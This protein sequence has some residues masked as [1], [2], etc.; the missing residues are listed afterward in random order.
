MNPILRNPCLASLIGLGWAALAASAQTPPP[1][2]FTHVISTAADSVTVD[3]VLRSIRSPNFGVI[4]Q[5]AD[6]SYANHTADVPRTYLG[7]VR[8]RPGALAGA[9]LRA[10]GT[11]WAQVV[12][13]TGAAWTTKGG[14]AQAIA[15]G[16]SSPLW[17]EQLVGEGGLGSTVYAV[18]TGLDIAY[19]HFVA[20]GGTPQ[21]AL[22]SAEFSL[23]AA[24]LPYLRDA[25]I[26]NRLGKI[27]IRAQRPHDPY[28]A[29]GTDK[30]ALLQRVRAL[31]TAGDPMGTTHHLAALIHRDLN[32]GLA[33]GGYSG[34][35][36]TSL[37]YAAVDSDNGEFWRVWRH[38]AGHNWGSGHTEG[39]AR[40][41][42]D[43]IMSG[44]NALSHFSSAEL[45][46]IVGHRN[47]QAALFQN[48]GTYPLPLP[49]R[50]NLDTASFHRNTPV[51]IDVLRNDSDMNG[52]ALTVV[53]SS[54]TTS[55][56]GLVT[57]LA[58]A[59]PGGRDV[60]Q[61]T[62]PPTLGSG[63][64]WFRYRIRDASGREGV[65][66]AVL[67]PRSSVLSLLDHWRL[68]NLAGTVA[69][70]RVRS[71]H[72]GTL[73]NGVLPGQP[74]L[75]PAT[76]KGV[77]FD[78]VDDRIEMP[79]S[80][81]TTD[82][83]SITAWIER[84]GNQNAWAP[85]F[86][87]RTA[88]T[89]CGIGFGTNNE[90]RYH[91]H[92]IG[93]TW[94][95]STPLIPPANEPCLVAL[96][97]GPNGA[98]IFLR[99]S[100]GL[101]S[102]RND[103]AHVSSYLI[104]AMVL[105]HDT[106]GT[107][108]YFK[109]ALDDVRIYQDTL[110]AAD[111]ESL[112]QQ[113]VSPPDVA[114][115]NPVADSMVP[116]LNIPVAASVGTF[117]ELVDRVDF[118]GDGTV[119][120]TDS[121]TPYQ[122]SIPVWEAG[123]RTLVARASYGDWSYQVDSPPVALTVAPPEPPV[124]SVTASL[125]AS[126]GG[127]TPGI[128]TFT[129]N[130]GYGEITVSLIP[131]GN[132][133]AGVDYQPIPETITFADGQLSQTIEVMP[134]AAAPD[135]KQEELTLTLAPGSGYSIGTS[136]ATLSIGDYA[137]YVWTKNAGGS[138]NTASN[139]NT[140][141]SVPVF[142]P[143][144]VVD[145]S[146][147]N[148]D[149]NRQLDLGSVGKIVGKMLF[150]DPTTPSNQWEIL[151]ENGPLTL[152]STTSQPVIET[153]D[154][155]S[156]ISVRLAGNQGFEKTGSSILRLNHSANDITGEIR[157]SQGTL[158]FRDGTTSTPTVFAAGTMAQRS[159]R[160]TGSGI[161]DLTRLSAT[162]TQDVT[163]TLPAVTLENAGTLRFRNN[164]AATYNHTMA[165]ALHVG[166]G[167]GRI[168]NSGGTGVQNVTLSGAL[169]GSGSLVYSG[170][171][172]TPRQLNI[173]GSN[174][175]FSGGWS[176]SHSG[177]GTAILRAAAAN[178][179]GTGVVTVGA[180]G[181]LLNDHATGLNSL[182]GVVLNGGNALL[183][184]NQPW[185]N[186]SA[187]LAMTGGTPVAEVGNAASSIGNLS[188]G[189]SAVLRGTG[190]ASVLTVNQ[191]A[192]QEFAGGVGPDLQLIQSGAAGLTLSGGL[193]ASLRLTAAQGRLALAGPPAAIAAV[194]QTGGDLAVN[195]V[196]PTTPS[197]VL[198][199]NFA[200]TGG[201]L[202]V[203]LPP[204]GFVT[205]VPYPLVVYQGS[206]TGQPP[207]EFAEPAPAVVDY[208]SGSNSVI[209]VTFHEAVLLTTLASP[210][211]GG[212]VSGGGFQQPGTEAV[213]T[214]TP[215]PG[216]QFDGWE[217]EGVIDAEHPASAVVMDGPKT[218]TAQF[219][220]DFDAWTRTHG[221]TDNDAL[222]GADPDQDG[223]TNDLE[224]RL[225]LDPID[226]GSRLKLAIRNGV[227]GNLVL[228]INRVVPDGTFTLESAA[229]PA[230]PW[231]GAIPVVVEAPQWDHDVTVPV[232]G[233]RGF[234]RLRYSP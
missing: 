68:D 184:L 124:V 8:G 216:W 20:A 110:A 72:N 186:S 92:N 172:G 126:K 14:T 1:A 177:T 207:V 145:F 197:L 234:F 22:D 105:G 13:D 64:D 123:A 87:S 228:T 190:P 80:N 212:T 203:G 16:G 140:D 137:T 11:V 81:L 223:M 162:S 138:W 21:G 189:A 219:I 33:Y 91:W 88:V 150:G 174:N 60:L 114:L 62:P 29:D 53:T 181:Q 7:T 183:K 96:S 202:R 58:G 136:A 61:Y 191:T 5:Q 221:L 70:N 97:I 18:E 179:L 187:S 117:G 209:T 103:V 31:W 167:G 178:A 151:G 130:H 161:L 233:P 32:G 143:D 146:K 129:R 125:P 73:Q 95:P 106:G 127:P 171:N 118:I 205:G 59:G 39:G 67:R 182:S 157:V 93:S 165:A 34:V 160:I 193:D 76:G 113:A 175:S 232:A 180:S 102:A 155:Q 210:P 25:G 52:E 198:T 50:A 215:A 231:V 195:L 188:G 2:T 199:G 166:S 57:R 38:E 185:N 24:N 230:G 120:A 46:K 133:V 227:D 192:D 147:V 112:Y 229:S 164:N 28:V 144:V 30:S 142:G 224:F 201:V 78:G 79:A 173:T 170:Q 66:F 15:T 45:V 115:T 44:D 43:T 99:D 101:K 222:P 48:L 149:A 196:D 122:T 65:N 214:A 131:S 4:V 6:G 47:Q 204:A 40:T 84:D 169:T 211:E 10:N 86:M 85:I 109:G 9:L 176:V 141:P 226:P 75:T 194:T 27:V 156:V 71:S 154:W 213:I 121:A 37:A 23:I 111:I 77:R 208:G 218:V 153:K 17:T 100:T 49:P 42:G 168:V 148:I 139:W 200:H 159:L 3:F 225:G 89:A 69:T 108:R 63:T 163:W 56:G 74:G 220:T 55:L 35:I 12:F 116:G 107:G 217:G 206:L 98:E 132:A 94:Q 158:Q 54:L 90:L 152:Q 41:E 135:G 119:L 26:E 134:I 82:T 128:F 104:G 51:M 36:G 83:L 19:S